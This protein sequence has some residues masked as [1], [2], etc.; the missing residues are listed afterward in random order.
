[1]HHRGVLPTPLD[2][3]TISPL[4]FLITEMTFPAGALVPNWCWVIGQILLG[5][6]GHWPAHS[7]GARFKISQH[8]LQHHRYF[9]VNYGLT[10]SEDRRYGTLYAEKV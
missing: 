5:A 3:G 7:A 9:T 10:P 2:S 8:H 6:V 4:E 1:M